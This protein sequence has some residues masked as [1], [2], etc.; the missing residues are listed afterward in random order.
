VQFLKT[1][2]KTLLRAFCHLTE[3]CNLWTHSYRGLQAQV[4][5]D[6]A[7]H[8]SAGSNAFGEGRNAETEFHGVDL[9]AFQNTK[10]KLSIYY[11][12]FAF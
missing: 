2:D 3:S 4:V 7:F 6:D 10:V 8:R 9:I 11:L 1:N 12:P 5:P